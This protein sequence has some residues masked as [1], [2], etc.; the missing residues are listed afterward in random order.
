MLLELDRAMVDWLTLST[1]GVID[2]RIFR[3]VMGEFE[4]GRMALKQE[5]AIPRYNGWRIHD[6]LNGGSLFVGSGIQKNKPHFLL[7]ASGQTANT[8]SERLLPVRLMGGPTRIDLQIT[9]NTPEG[10]CQKEL[11]AESEKMKIGSSLAGTGRLRTVYMGS[12]KSRRFTRVYLK[13]TDA[14]EVVRLEVVFRDELAKSCWGLMRKGCEIKKILRS[15]M[16]PT[17]MLESAFGKLLGNETQVVR[18]TRPV[19][20][21]EKWLWRQVLPAIESYI[22]SHDSNPEIAAHLQLILDRYHGHNYPPI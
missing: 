3:K 6:P 9:T 17:P 19:T 10:W 18:R 8:V 22:N 14:G 13:D 1:F 11:W 5:A 16:P 21:T 15:A 7:T 4:S 2:W 20:N 12:P